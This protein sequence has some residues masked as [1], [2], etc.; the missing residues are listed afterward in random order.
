MV[1]NLELGKTIQY[2]AM[3]SAA[4]NVSRGYKLLGRE[5]V[6][7]P[8]IDNCFENHIKNQREKLLNVAD[9][10]GLHFQGDGATIKENTLLNILAGGYTYLCQSKILWTVQV[11]SQVVTRSM[12]IVLMRVS[13][14][15]LMNLIQ[16]RN[17]WT[18]I[19][20]MEP[21][22]AERLKTYWRL[23]IIC[24]HVFL[25]QSITAIICLKGG[26]LLRK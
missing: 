19:F 10:Y 9:I 23:F 2:R 21:V 8:L 20:L 13:F 25:E 15:Q 12:L 4:R 16:R 6:W 7:G 11:I 24:C 3:I 17:F 26:H 5:T 22:C 18:Y 1:F 14:I